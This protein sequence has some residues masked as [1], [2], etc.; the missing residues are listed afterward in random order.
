M[1]AFLLYFFVILTLVRFYLFYLSTQQYVILPKIKQGYDYIQILVT[2]QSTEIKTVNPFYNTILIVYDEYF[3][4][5]DL[6]LDA[7]YTRVAYSSRRV[8]VY[9]KTGWDIYVIQF[10]NFIQILNLIYQMNSFSFIMFTWE[11]LT[12]LIIFSNKNK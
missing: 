1:G 11:N 12:P 8:V 10:A 9:Y 6:D 3:W 5:L 7:R 2:T 4:T